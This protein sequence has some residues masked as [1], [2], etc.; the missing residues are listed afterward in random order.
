MTEKEKVVDVVV[1]VAKVSRT[2]YDSSLAKFDDMGT[3]HNLSNAIVEDMKDEYKK[4][5]MI[6]GTKIDTHI[7]RLSNMKT[8]YKD[9]LSSVNQGI[10]DFN[11]Q[12]IVDGVVLPKRKRGETLEYDAQ[13][14]LKIVCELVDYDEPLEVESTKAPKG[15]K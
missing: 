15:G 14:Q 13:P 10:Q 3:K 11:L 9:F 4:T 5:H 7:I 6:K 8:S 1:E 12:L 2:Q